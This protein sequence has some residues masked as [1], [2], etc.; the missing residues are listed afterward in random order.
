MRYALR[1]FTATPVPIRYKLDT[2]FDEALHQFV[3]RNTPA[4][5]PVLLAHASEPFCVRNHLHLLALQKA[6]LLVVQDSE[7]LEQVI[8]VDSELPSGC[9]A[10]AWALVNAAPDVYLQYVAELSR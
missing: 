8:R 4:R 1:G 7:S 2:A 5:S 3:A 9:Y 6:A 10:R